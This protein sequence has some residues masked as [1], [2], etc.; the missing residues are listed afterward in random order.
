[1]NRPLHMC[2]H[3]CVISVKR[4][5]DSFVDHTSNGCNDS[6]L[7]KAMPYAELIAKAQACAQIWDG[8][9]TAL[10]VLLNCGNVSGTLCTGS[11]KMGIPLWLH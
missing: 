4:N 9:C 7:D 8:T 5:A 1:M 11:G 6:H 10:E 2:T 3:G